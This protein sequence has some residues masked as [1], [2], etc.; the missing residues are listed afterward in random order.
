MIFTNELVYILLVS[1]ILFSILN[2]LSD[3]LVGTIYGIS[4]TFVLG[5]LGIVLSNMFISMLAITIMIGALSAG[6]VKFIFYI[7]GL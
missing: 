1:I 6:I 5:L 3:K 4:L 2:L 7:G